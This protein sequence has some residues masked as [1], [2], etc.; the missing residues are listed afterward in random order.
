MR[1]SRK[2]DNM[3]LTYLKKKKKRQDKNIS[4]DSGVDFS[5]PSTLWQKKNKIKKFYQLDQGWTFN[6]AFKKGEILLKKK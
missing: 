1:E 3:M 6:L 4:A 2:R 5:S